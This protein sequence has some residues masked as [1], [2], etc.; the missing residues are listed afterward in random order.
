MKTDT[1]AVVRRRG[2]TLIELLVVIAIIA[3]LAG[4]LLP[5]LA[6]S[7][8]KAQQISC[9]S[10]IKQVGLALHMYTDDNRDYLPPNISGNGLNAGQYGGYGTF[11]S[12]VK[13]LLPAYLY[14]YLQ[15]P[16]PSTATNLV[17]VM[18]CPAAVHYIPPT[19]IDYWHREYF[20]LYYPNFVDNTNLTMVAFA[21]FGHY[22]ASA[23]GGDPSHPLSDFNGLT[24]I[25]R[26]WIMADLD[27]TALKTST[28]SWSKNTPPTPPHG[29]VR[30][31]SYFD[32]HAAAQRIPA[33]GKF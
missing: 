27:Q 29:N 2:F 32:G 6:K 16:A 8:S 23:N 19:P 1:Q 33:S 24:S 14:S 12:D 17:Q 7:K 20:A 31:Y 21:P 5:A 3:I 4:L 26:M 18:L 28:P 13:G 22:S 15:L 10:G 30:N 9:L 11:L 25:D